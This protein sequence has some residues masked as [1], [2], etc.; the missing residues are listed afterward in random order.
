M[1]LVRVMALACVMVLARVMV[2]VCVMV[3]A[4]VTLCYGLLSRPQGLSAGSWAHRLLV[5][6]KK[7]VRESTDNP[8]SSLSALPV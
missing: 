3:L 2:L 6:D 7:K 1:V 8:L 5:T 4:H